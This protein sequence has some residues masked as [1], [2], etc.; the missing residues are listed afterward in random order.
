LGALALF[1]NEEFVNVNN[2]QTCLLDIGLQCNSF[3]GSPASSG[4]INMFVKG[5]VLI[6]TLNDSYLLSHVKLFVTKLAS[7]DV[8]LGSPW[9]KE[10]NTF[11]GG[12]NNDIVIY[13][14]VQQISSV[15]CNEGKV[16]IEQFSDVFVT[17]AVADLPPHWP[18]FDCQVNLK[19]GAIPPFGKMYNLSKDEL[20]ELKSYVEENLKKGFIHISSSSAAAPIF[21]VK[22]AGK[23]NCP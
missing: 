7:A 13:D 8:I 16:L 23:A 5:N 9:L 11:I 21:Y 2:L 14:V 1:V 12:L 17:E 6:P 22:V 15:D 18:N 10:S 20:D 19:K 3:D 4:D